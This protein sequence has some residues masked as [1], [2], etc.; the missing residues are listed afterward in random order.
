MK[1]KI[2]LIIKAISGSSITIVYDNSEI[3]YAYLSEEN[4]DI[5]HTIKSIMNK[6]K[7]HEAFYS[8][9]I[10]DFVICDNEPC[11]YYTILVPREY[12]YGLH[13]ITMTDE[14][15]TRNQIDNLMIRS[16]LSKPNN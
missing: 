16:A 9:T 8:P 2:K 7:V 6:F 1:T 14:L 5:V 3:P 4:P 11:V 10:I 12:I 13:E 15:I